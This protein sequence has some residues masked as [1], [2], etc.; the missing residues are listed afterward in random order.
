MKVEVVTPEENMGDVIGDLN[1]RRGLVQGMDDGVGGVKLVRAK[2]RL[3]KCLGTR[4]TSVVLHKVAHLTAWSLR[5]MPKHHQA[6]QM[7]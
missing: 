2:F 4:Q 5:N 7:K 3:Q 6:S 1:R